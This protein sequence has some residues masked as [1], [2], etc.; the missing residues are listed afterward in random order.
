[1]LQMV[2]F[3]S[4]FIFFGRIATV[5]LNIMTEVS[6]FALTYVAQDAKGSRQEKCCLHIKPLKDYID[7]NISNFR[8]KS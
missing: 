3:L 4:F 5:T 2:E 8:M 7:Q 6:L 1:M